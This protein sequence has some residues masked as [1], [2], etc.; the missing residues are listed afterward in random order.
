MKNSIYRTINIVA[1]KLFSRLCSPSEKTGETENLNLDTI[2]KTKRRVLL[3]MVLFGNKVREKIV[4]TLDSK[5]SCYSKKSQF[6]S[7][8]SLQSYAFFNQHLFSSQATYY[9]SKY[10]T[11]STSL[12]STEPFFQLYFFAVVFFNQASKEV[13]DLWLCLIQC[14]SLGTV[15]CTVSQ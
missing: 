13:L 6:Y 9:A 5:C 14:T 2:I 12:Y 3:I 10:A 8:T 15:K 1:H 11:R 7:L 4:A